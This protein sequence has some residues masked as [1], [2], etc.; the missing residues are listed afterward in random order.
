MATRHP[1]RRMGQLASAV[2][3]PA[4][5]SGEDITGAGA[6]PDYDYGL[7]NSAHYI[8]LGFVDIPRVG[9]QA[10]LARDNHPPREMVL[11][12]RGTQSLYDGIIDLRVW[13]VRMDWRVDGARGHRGFRQQAVELIRW[14][15]DRHA[16]KFDGR[17][18]TFTGHSMGAA[19]ARHASGLL[20]LESYHVAS[21]VTFGGP[22]DC[23]QAWEDFLRIGGGAGINYAHRSDPVTHVPA[24]SVAISRWFP[25]DLYC[26]HRRTPLRTDRRW[27]AAHSMSA[28]CESLAKSLD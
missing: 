14:L 19:I 27:I 2:Y 23:N 21:P 5:R 6:T 26:S 7:V 28:Y 3:E 18:I 10:L 15:I 25:V 16:D 17:P 1:H 20:R 22:N 11:A 8:P 12:V 24:V 13:P 4:A 9:L